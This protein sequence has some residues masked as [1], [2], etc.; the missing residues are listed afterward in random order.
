MK[1]KT[2]YRRS[3][4]KI[5]TKEAK[6]LKHLRESSKLSLRGAAKLARLSEAKLNHSENG[7]CDLNPSLILKIIGAYNVNY[8]EFMELVRGSKQMPVNEYSECI[9]MV[10]RL[11]KSKI[12]TLRAILESF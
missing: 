1:K 10:K 6:V 12:R 7:R 2:K 4:L 11:D 3:A 8:Y 9:E 5:M